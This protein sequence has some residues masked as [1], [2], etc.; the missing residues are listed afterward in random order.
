MVA[1]SLTSLSTQA[2]KIS[3]RQAEVMYRKCAKNV[4]HHVDNLTFL[5]AEERK[6][7]MDKHIAETEAQLRKLIRPLKPLKCLDEME[8]QFARLMPRRKMLVL[9][10]VSGCG[11]TEAIKAYCLAICGD[12]E[13]LLEVNCA[14]TPEPNLRDLVWPQHIMVLLD[15]IAVQAVCDQRRVLQGPN[16]R[17]GLGCSATN[18]HAYN[19]YTHGL[20]ICI[21]SNSWTEQLKALQFD[22]DRDWI[23]ANTI[24]YSVPPGETL[25]VDAPDVVAPEC[26]SGCP[27]AAAPASATVPQAVVGTTA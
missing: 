7:A 3:C 11:K 12:P 26:S 14:R 13:R 25:Y 20:R 22:G 21:C 6:L 9:E 18:I 5:T 24:H 2:G 23:E 8:A 4:K 19:V 1:P 16:A 15:E 27:P 17:L 10:G